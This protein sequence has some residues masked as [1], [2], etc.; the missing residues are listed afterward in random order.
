MSLGGVET[1]G[2]KKGRLRAAPDKDNVPLSMRTSLPKFMLEEL[3][4]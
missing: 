4:L 2:K 1:W 3:L